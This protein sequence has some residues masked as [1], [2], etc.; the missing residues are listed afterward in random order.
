MATSSTARFGATAAARM[1]TP[2][3]MAARHMVRARGLA[4]PAE[5][6]PPTAAPAPMTEAIT[7]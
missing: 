1:A 3:P 7:P 5:M 6:R 4:R 2:Q